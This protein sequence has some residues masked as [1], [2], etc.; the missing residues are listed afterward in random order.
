MSRDPLDYSHIWLGTFDGTKKQFQKC[1]DLSSFFAAEEDD[2]F[3]KCAFS[4]YLG[5]NAYSDEIFSFHFDSKRKIE[6]LVEG[7]V[8]PPKSQKQLLKQCEELG[9]NKPNAAVKYGVFHLE[10]G[11]SLAE[12]FVGLRYFGEFLDP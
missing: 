2:P 10:D 6:T 11:S 9:I 1:F 5:V 3:D 4:E 12:E 7:L 8:L